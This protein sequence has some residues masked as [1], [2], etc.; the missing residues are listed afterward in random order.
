MVQMPPS[1]NSGFWKQQDT[2]QSICKDKTALSESKAVMGE[3]VVLA[4]MDA[5]L[6]GN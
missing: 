3:M 5:T 6:N 1:W 4:K 2:L